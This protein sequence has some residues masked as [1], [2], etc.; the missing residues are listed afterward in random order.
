[1]NIRIRAMILAIVSTGKTD[2]RVL[3]KQLAQQFSTSKQRIS[4]NISFLVTT[5]AVQIKRQK[6]HSYIY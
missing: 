1:M 4:G 2:T 6:P 3:I 5:G